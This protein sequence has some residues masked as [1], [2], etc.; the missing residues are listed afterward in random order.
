MNICRT[1]SRLSA[2]FEI[3]NE[4]SAGY[5]KNYPLA[6]LLNGNDGADKNGRKIDE[7]LNEQLGKTVPF[8]NVEQD[9][10]HKNTPNAFVKM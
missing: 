9:F 8:E 1:V 6:L 7:F 4:P 5:L 3:D 10:L 2:L